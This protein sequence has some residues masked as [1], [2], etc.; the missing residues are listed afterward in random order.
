MVPTSECQQKIRIIVLVP[1]GI[2]NLIGFAQKIHWMAM[3]DHY[4]VLYLGIVNDVEKSLSVSRRI[5]TLRAATSENRLTVSGKLAPAQEWFRILRE[6]YQPGDIIVCHEEQT[7]K[8]GFFRRMPAKYFLESAFGVPINVI[9]GFYNPQ[10]VQLKQWAHNFLFWIGCL[11]IVGIF[12]FLET[13]MEQYTQGLTRIMIL[14]ILVLFE[15]GLF[16]TLSGTTE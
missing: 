11:V 7:V 14:M 4:D 12:S 3:N 13:Q 8:N 15:V 16:W 5:A 10:S 2:T 9:T 1:E 6:T